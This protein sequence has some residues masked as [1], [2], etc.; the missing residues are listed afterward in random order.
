[1]D[2]YNTVAI[3]SAEQIKQSAKQLPLLDHFREN[4][5]IEMLLFLDMSLKTHTPL[6]YMMKE[7]DMTAYFWD[8]F[9][10]NF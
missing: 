8:I 1:M 9:F 2:N 4:L 10:F 6:H 7:G 3:E 5:E